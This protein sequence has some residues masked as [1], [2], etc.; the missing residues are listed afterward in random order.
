MK[1][2]I[3]AK[4]NFI[5]ENFA[6]NEKNILLKYFTNVDKPVF[7]LINMPEVVKSALFARYS[8]TNKSLRRLFLDEFYN[9]S[10][11][12]E[13]SIVFKS[14]NKESGVDRADLLFDKVFVEYGDDSVAQLGG[15]HIACEQA[16]NILAKV[17]ERGRLA[18]YLEQSTRY[19]FYNM[20][21]DNKY[22]YITPIEIVNA[23]LENEYN[24]YMDMLFDTYTEITDKLIHKLKLKFPKENNQSVRAWETTLKAKACDIVRGLLPAS[25][26]TNIGIYASGQAYEILLIKMFSSSNQEVI[27]Y[28]NMMLVELRKIIPSFLKRVDLEDR[29]K[30]WSAYFSHINVEMQKLSIPSPIRHDMEEISSKVEL[31]DW[32]KDAV[33][34]VVAAALYEVS[35]VSD[36][37]LIEYCKKLND[38]NKEEIL[39]V[40]YGNRANRRHKPGR[41]LETVFYRF[42]VLSDYG[43]FRDLQRHRML[44]ILWQKLSPINGYKLPEELDEYPELKLLYKSSIEKAGSYF[45]KIKNIVNEDIAQYLVPFAYNIRYMFN[46]NLREAIHLLELRTQKQG[47]IAYRKIC[48]DMYSLI[49]VKTNHDLLLKG[50]RYIDFSTYELSR[51]DAEKKMD[52]MSININDISCE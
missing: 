19:V 47:H 20:K 45:N 44:T 51:E 7:G 28:A 16:S 4:T 26:R 24:S 49:K 22:N 14:K 37:N 2:S 1:D 48:W 15:A 27:D 32:D 25:T 43:A 36:H 30:R 11:E 13:D 21:T 38:Q 10:V 12:N 42:D 33:D 8:R 18:A 23:G 29:G 52:K 5:I 17:I 40:Y 6:E 31:V 35:E 3:S 9:K 50:F 46:I 41:A 34:K 39:K